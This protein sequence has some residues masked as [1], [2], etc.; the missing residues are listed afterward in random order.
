MVV[1]TVATVEATAMKT[2]ATNP[3]TVDTASVA[4]TAALTVM[5]PV[6]VPVPVVAPPPHLVKSDTVAMSVM[7]ATTDAVVVA[8]V[9]AVVQEPRVVPTMAVKSATMNNKRRAK[10]AMPT[11]VAVDMT[12]VVTNATLA[13]ELVR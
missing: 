10:P 7:V 12:T 5:V 8:A 9:V 11:A 2:E 4:T 6:P 3:T 1:A 13:D